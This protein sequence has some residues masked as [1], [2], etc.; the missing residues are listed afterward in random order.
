MLNKKPDPPRRIF[1][2]SKNLP[3]AFAS[4][5]LCYLSR[6][7]AGASPEELRGANNFFFF[8]LAKSQRRKEIPVH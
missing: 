3:E 4:S 7:I 6:S 5:L 8:I 2:F 1:F